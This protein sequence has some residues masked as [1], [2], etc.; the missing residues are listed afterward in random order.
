[1]GGC[2]PNVA[3]T[4]GVVMAAVV[5]VVV[6]MGIGVPVVVNTGVGVVAMVVD[7]MAEDALAALCPLAHIWHCHW[8]A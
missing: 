1:M 8:A 5:M 7:G 3:L 2:P 4:T 6:A